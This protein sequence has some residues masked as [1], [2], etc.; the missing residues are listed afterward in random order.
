[1]QISTNT[2]NSTHNTTNDDLAKPSITSYSFGSVFFV[3]SNDALSRT[4][5]TCTHAIIKTE[6][7]LYKRY[8]QTLHF[9]H[10]ERER[11]D[12]F[13]F[14]DFVEVESALPEDLQD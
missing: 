6:E 7:V 11:E 13:E 4:G 10:F 14:L 12:A 9:Q 3:A 1:M 8:I 5:S 2:A